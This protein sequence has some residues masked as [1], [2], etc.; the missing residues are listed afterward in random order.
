M[1]VEVESQRLT[2]EHGYFLRLLAR[3]LKWDGLPR[4]ILNTSHARP[5]L[6]MLCS[7][8]HLTAP[9]RLSHLLLLF[10]GINLWRRD[11]EWYWQL[12]Q[13]WGDEWIVLQV[14]DRFVSHTGSCFDCRLICFSSCIRSLPATSW[15]CGRSHL[16][17][18]WW[19]MSPSRSLQIPWRHSSIFSPYHHLLLC[20]ISASSL[21]ITICSCAPS[22]LY[23]HSSQPS[24]TQC[25]LSGIGAP[26]AAPSDTDAAGNTLSWP[27]TLTHV[28][29][30]FALFINVV[31]GTV[32]TNELRP[33]SAATAL[34][35]V[36]NQLCE[37][38]PNTYTCTDILSAK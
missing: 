25:P 8:I 9:E 15:C 10:L 28:L 16:I 7:C 2:L 24:H 23:L 14:S 35:L 12:D 5:W 31:A 37:Q 33:F 4:L 1:T 26:S 17:T 38:F 30:N 19:E 32:S 18:S 36:T 6:F 13:V 29:R 3:L 22:T 20:S 21:H 27:C 34:P 11:A